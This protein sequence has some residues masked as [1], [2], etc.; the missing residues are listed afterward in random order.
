[1][2]PAKGGHKIQ[3]SPPDW[4]QGK[5]DPQP[6]LHTL[7]KTKN[8]TVWD[9]TGAACGAFPCGFGGWCPHQGELKIHN[10]IS[11][12]LLQQPPQK[13]DCLAGWAQ[14]L[15]TSLKGLLWCFH[16][17]KSKVGSRQDLALAQSHVH[18]RRSRGRSSPREQALWGPR[19]L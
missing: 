5:P 1:M 6:A 18:L 11:I 8:N 10:E 12:Q 17:W 15:S 14:F 7:P 9:K 16:W 3:S 2:A 4:G 13:T 19:V